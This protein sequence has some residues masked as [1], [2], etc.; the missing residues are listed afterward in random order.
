MALRSKRARTSASAKW[1][2]ERSASPPQ[3]L[4]PGLIDADH[5]RMVGVELPD[6]GNDPG[7]HPQSFFLGNAQDLCRVHAGGT[8]P[9]IDLAAVTVHGRIDKFAGRREQALKIVVP[10][11]SPVRQPAGV[12]LKKR[13]QANPHPLSAAPLDLAIADRPVEFAFFHLD[14]ARIDGHHRRVERRQE[15]LGGCGIHFRTTERAAQERRQTAG[16]PAANGDHLLGKGR[17]HEL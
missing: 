12:G 13:S 16:R 6:P 4:A 9:E 7:H 1:M 15:G 2:G 14:I 3:V 11:I 10:E 5:R 8:V 17:R